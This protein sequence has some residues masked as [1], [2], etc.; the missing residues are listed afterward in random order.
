MV[1]AAGQL[2]GGEQ[3]VVMVRDG[4]AKTSPSGSK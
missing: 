4:R 1:V 2:E 3:G